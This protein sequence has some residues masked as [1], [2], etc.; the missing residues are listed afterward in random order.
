MI[1]KALVVKDPAWQPVS[2]SPV[3]DTDDL[4]AAYL[5]FLLVPENAKNDQNEAF[6]CDDEWMNKHYNKSIMF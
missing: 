5:I 2:F 6:I 4:S 3:S 1:Y